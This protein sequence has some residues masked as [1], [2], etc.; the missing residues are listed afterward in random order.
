MTNE[1]FVDFGKFDNHATNCFGATNTLH[2]NEDGS[3]LANITTRSDLAVPII[4]LWMKSRNA[5]IEL[6]TGIHPLPA[7]ATI[8]S[9]FLRAAP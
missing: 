1:L 8:W 4:K 6:W 2:R 7:A 5:G 9:S 3:N